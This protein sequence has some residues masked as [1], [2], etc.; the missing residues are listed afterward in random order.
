MMIRYIPERQQTVPSRLLFWLRVCVIVGL[1]VAV[2]VASTP[3]LLALQ[4]NVFALL[5]SY[6]TYF[7][8]HASGHDLF[9]LACGGVALPC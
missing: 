7:L 3:A 6:L 9:V 2:V 1:A 5:T 8:L 4:R